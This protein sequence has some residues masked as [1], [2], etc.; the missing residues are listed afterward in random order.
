M[1]AGQF[2][3]GGV[4]PHPAHYL[5]MWPNWSTIGLQSNCLHQH[6]VGSSACY[7]LVA[8]WTLHIK[9]AVSSVG[10]FFRRSSSIVSPSRRSCMIWS[11]IFLCKHSSEQNLHVFELKSHR[12]FHL[13][14]WTQFLK[15][16]MLHWFVDWPSTYCCI[17]ATMS[18][19]LFLW[20]LLMPRLSTVATVSLAK[21][22]IVRLHLLGRTCWAGFS[23]AR[24]AGLGRPPIGPSK[25]WSPVRDHSGG[26]AWVNLL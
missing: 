26:R 18:L 17:A 6:I 13:G 10:S 5:C 7:F 21:Q 15:I 14:C 1:K 12:M 19:T 4:E 8:S 11:Q 22:I 9:L 3:D 24:P 25:L 16:T 20:S 23:L 2:Q